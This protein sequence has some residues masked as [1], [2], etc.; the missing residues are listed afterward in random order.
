MEG[1]HACLTLTVFSHRQELCSSLKAEGDC[2]CCWLHCCCYRCC[3]LKNSTSPDFG[4]IGRLAGDASSDACRSRHS[5]RLISQFLNVQQFGWCLRVHQFANRLPLSDTDY[6]FPL[7]W[8][9]DGSGRA[10][11][12]ANLLPIIF[13][14]S[15]STSEH[16]RSS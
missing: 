2:F 4:Q 7:I 15:F 13:G 12:Q 6:G 5:C 11:E 3:Y 16:H 1:L 9:L 10:I 14:R 8:S